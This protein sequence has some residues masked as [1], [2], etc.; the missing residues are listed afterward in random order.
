MILICGIFIHLKPKTQE[1]VSL[2]NRGKSV[3]AVCG[4]LGVSPNLQN[5]VRRILR[6]WNNG[7]VKIVG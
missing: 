7:D 4:R 1:I 3:R 2:L 6:A 5:N